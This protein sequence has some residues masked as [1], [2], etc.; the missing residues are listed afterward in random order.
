ML[1]ENC[2]LTDSG[3]LLSAKMAFTKARL[4]AAL[5]QRVRSELDA[6]L[7]SAYRAELLAVRLGKLFEQTEAKGEY[8]NRVLVAASFVNMRDYFLIATPLED[9]GYDHSYKIN[10]IDGPLYSYA[11]TVG[12]NGELNYEIETLGGSGLFDAER[13]QKLSDFLDDLEANSVIYPYTEE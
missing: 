10:D 2:G 1:N 5:D 13:L 9:D 3:L 8:T 12:E 6:E 11:F 7:N 4:E